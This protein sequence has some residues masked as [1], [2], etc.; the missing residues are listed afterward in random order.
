MIVKMRQSSR[1]F[2][3]RFEDML[4]HGENS[5]ILMVVIYVA[6]AEAL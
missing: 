1:E 2:I 5:E 6:S 3:F 4:I